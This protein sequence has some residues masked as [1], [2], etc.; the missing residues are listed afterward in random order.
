MPAYQPDPES[1]AAHPVPAWFGEA[2][3][4][5]L[6][7]WGLYSV[8]AWAPL[9]GHITDLLRDRFGETCKLSPYAEWYENSLRFPDGPTAAHHA[10]AWPG[11]AYADFRGPFE[12]ALERWRPEPWAELFAEAGV[13]YVVPVTKHHDGF[14]LWPSGAETPLRGR[15]SAPRDVVGELAA[16]CRAGGQRF[17]VYYSGGLDW[18]FD[19]RPVANLGEMLASV[20]TSVAYRRHVLTHYGELI[21]RYDPDLLW[22]DIAYPDAGDLWGLLAGFYGGR[23]DRLVNDRFGPAGPL[24]ARL[25]DPDALARFNARMAERMTEPGLAFAPAPPPV[26]DYRTPEYAGFAD[27]QPE[28]WECV[29]GLSSSFGFKRNDPDR[30]D[31]PAVIR[32]LADVVSRNGNLLLGVGPD[33]EGRIVEPERDALLALGAWLRVNGEAVFGTTPWRC[34]EG[35][36]GAGTPIRFTRRRATVHAIVLERLPPGPCTLDGFGEGARPDR[37]RVLGRG[38]VPF[39]IEPGGRLAVEI[40]PGLDAEPAVTLALDGAA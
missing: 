19:A 25:Q 9:T 6:I 27:I 30:L 37:V 10:Q 14:T 18:S 39:R 8:P 34:A 4:G 22:N 40:P 5:V 3:L 12:A 17:G 33:A 21:E 2:K 26:F 36:T 38:E 13:R 11:W 15:W 35:L 7:H 29:R 24:Q 1:L 32:L 28:P 16:A 23:E 31:G 20:P